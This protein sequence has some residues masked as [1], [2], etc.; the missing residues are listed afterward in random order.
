MYGAIL[1]HFWAEIVNIIQNSKHYS[2]VI[3][4]DH[5]KTLEHKTKQEKD[6]AIAN[7]KA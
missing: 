6:E 1:F 3:R 7:S 4:E 5:M 2:Q